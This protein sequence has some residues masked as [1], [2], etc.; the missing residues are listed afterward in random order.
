MA[1]L[2][3]V[4][5]K[6][7]DKRADWIAWGE[8]RSG[9][10]LEARHAV[11]TYARSGATIEFDDRSKATLGENSL[12]VIRGAEQEASPQA[13]RDR[14]VSLLVT[15]GELRATHAPGEAGMEI[16][17][18][19]GTG[20]IPKEAPATDL[21]VSVNPD[22]TSTFSVY[23]GRAEVTEA[24]RTV[25]VNANQTVTVQAGLPPGDPQDLPGIPIPTEPSSGSVLAYRSVPP[26]VHMAWTTAERAETY[27]VDIARDRVFHDLVDVIDRLPDAQFVHGNLSKGVYYWRVRALRGWADGP[28]SAVQRVET[29]EDRE[30]PSLRVDFPEGP[31]AED[32]VVLR[33]TAERGA[34]VFVRSGRVPTDQDG[35]FEI[36]LTLRRGVNVVVVEALDAAGNATYRSRLLDAKY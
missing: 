18:G 7:K 26:R 21:K 4:Y 16:I 2:T 27:R 14:I 30:P 10:P 6:V 12:M 24:G 35:R 29:A 5:R 9:M 25:H 1:R 23:G 32:S 13:P 31:V 19:A 28:P 34:D 3:D 36:P 22:R 17:T 15:A 20:R 8:A 11:Q 33:G